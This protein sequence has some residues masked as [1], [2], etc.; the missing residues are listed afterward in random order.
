MPSLLPFFE[1]CEAT[2]LGQLIRNS[3]VSFA[4]IETFHL[5][6]LTV[7]L[8]AIFILNLRLY[9]LILRGLPVRQLALELSP[10]TFWSL[11]LILVSG[12]LLFASEAIKCYAST[13]FRWKMVFLF[14]ALI[15][16]FTFYRK[17]T[18]GHRDPGLTVGILIGTISLFLWFGVGV[19]GRA[20]GFF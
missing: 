8:G 15:F 9:R 13:P 17:I 19:G 3:L 2:W 10:W 7:L 1:W 11:V 18:R 12:A 16:H 5:F 14:F 20:I 6:A 4:V